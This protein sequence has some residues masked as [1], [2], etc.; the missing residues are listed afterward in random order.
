MQGDS[1]DNPVFTHVPGSVNAGVTIEN[2][3][4]NQVPLVSDKSKK[5]SL[6][7]P[8]VPEAAKKEKN[9]LDAYETA[10][11]KKLSTSQLQRLVLLEQLEVLRLKKARINE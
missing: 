3:S 11:T 6:P 2:E 1:K 4:E 9:L 8:P 5:R 10:E 7:L